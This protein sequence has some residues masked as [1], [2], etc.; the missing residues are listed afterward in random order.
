[1]K[2]KHAR[3]SDQMP[4][5]DTTGKCQGECRDRVREGE[6]ERQESIASQAYNEPSPNSPSWTRS[7]KEQPGVLGGRV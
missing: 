2:R 1:M 7:R 6:E 3:S 5:R 4:T